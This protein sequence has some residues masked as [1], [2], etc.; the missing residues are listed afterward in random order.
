MSQDS[1]QK[2]SSTRIL[3]SST[4]FPKLET[5]ST[6]VFPTW[7]APTKALLHRRKTPMMRNKKVFFKLINEGVEEGEAIK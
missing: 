3:Y 6:D 5:Y 2:V 7:L 1:I 4:V